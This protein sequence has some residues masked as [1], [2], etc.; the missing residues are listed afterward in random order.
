MV[1][2]AKNKS[3]NRNYLA[4]I[5]YKGVHFQATSIQK[6]YYLSDM[7]RKHWALLLSEIRKELKYDL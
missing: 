3:F 5:N 2:I 1:Y 7:D 4:V 6:D